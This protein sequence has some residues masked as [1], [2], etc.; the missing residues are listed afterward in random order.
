MNNIIEVVAAILLRDGEKGQEYLLAQ[1]PAGKVYAGYW[2][3]PGGKVEAGE[4]LREAL[5]RELQE[6]LGIT[7]DRAWPWLS[8]EF[9]YPHANVR[10][11]FFR[12]VSWDGE[13][14]PIEHSGLIWARIGGELPVT[15]VLPANTPILRALE[16]PSIYALTNATENGVDAELE[17]LERAL[18]EGL[19]LIQVRDKTLPLM[20]RRRLAMGVMSLVKGC[21]DAHVLINDDEALAREVNAHGLHLSSEKLMQLAERPAFDWVA[22]SCHATNELSRAASLGV[23]FVLLSPI[24]PTKSHPDAEIIGWDEFSRLIE[25]VALPVFALGGMSLGMLETARRRGAHG[26]A[27]M[28]AWD[29]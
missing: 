22:A 16:L 12:V 13:I 14:V 11:K 6:E 18:A 1:R 7:V 29:K 23:D 3:F 5:V 25:R 24:L 10:L 27:L 21:A 26:I 2:E 17:K 8:C 4:T 28:R 19:R 15:P 20:Q 9:S